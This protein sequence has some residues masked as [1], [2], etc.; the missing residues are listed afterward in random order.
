[1]GKVAV[2]LDPAAQLVYLRALALDLRREIPGQRRWL[3]HGP[4]TPLRHEIAL[5]ENEP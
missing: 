4:T 5:V 2:L 3:R 1:L